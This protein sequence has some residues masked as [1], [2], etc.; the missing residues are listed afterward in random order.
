MEKENLVNK[1]IQW[2]DNIDYVE[3]Y[4]RGTLTQ[5]MEFFC[6]NYDKGYGMKC[7]ILETLN[8][9][10]KNHKEDLTIKDLTKLFEFLTK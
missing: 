6:S 8:D 4:E 5:A 7:A 10:F 3:E 9:Q 1:I 2:L